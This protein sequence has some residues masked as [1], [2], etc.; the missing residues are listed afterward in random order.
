MR[1]RFERHPDADDVF[2]FDPGSA[3]A[4]LPADHVSPALRAEYEAEL[5]AAGLVPHTPTGSAERPDSG[6]LDPDWTAAALQRSITALYRHHR[7]DRVLRE[8]LLEAEAEFTALR[9]VLH[10]PLR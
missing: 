7:H 1:D 4:L 3:A 2:T 5:R 6:P 8:R 9:A 10:S